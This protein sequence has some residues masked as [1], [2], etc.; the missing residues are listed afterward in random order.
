MENWIP[1]SKSGWDTR[2]TVKFGLLWGPLLTWDFFSNIGSLVKKFRF[3]WKNPSLSDDQLLSK[4][5]VEKNPYE[6]LYRCD[7][8]WR[9]G[10]RS[11]NRG[12]KRG[13]QSNWAFCEEHFWLEICFFSNIRSL[14]K[15]FWARW[16]NPSLSDDQLLSKKEVEKNPSETLYRCDFAWRIGFR[17]RNR[18]EKP[19]TQS[20]LA[21]CGD[22]FWLEIFFQHRVTRKKN[23]GPRKKSVPQWRPAT[24]QEGSRK[25]PFRD[26]L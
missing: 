2:H 8:A 9:I 19:G 18:G 14:V 11:R 1:E 5:E 24:F 16:K 7:F 20:N 23:L 10:F 26:P 3:R 21:F 22:H 17:C 6:T 4:K 12:E 25:K 13:T 15:K